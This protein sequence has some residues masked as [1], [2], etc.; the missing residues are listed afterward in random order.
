MGDD[1]TVLQALGLSANEQA[2]Y[3]LLLSRPPVTGQT[4]RELTADRVWAGATEVALRRLEELGL[5]ARLPHDPPRYVVI[6][7]D[8]GLEALIAARERS[9]VAARQR[10]NQ[11]AVRYRQTTIGGDPLDLVEV[12]HGREAVQARLKE[13]FRSVRTE[14]RAIDAPPYLGDPLDTSDEE[15]E[16]LRDGVRYRIIYDRQAVSLPGRLPEIEGSVVAGE[17]ARVTDVAL[18]LG[19]SDHPLAMLPLRTHPVDLETWLVIHDSVLLDALS[20]LFEM[21]WERAVPLHI[22]QERPDMTGHDAPNETD[23]A[24]LSLLA[25]GLTDKAVADHL[26]W[27]ERTAHRHLRLMMRRLDATTRF[28]AGYQAVRRGWLTHPRNGTDGTQ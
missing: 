17:E 8:A 21:Y 18:K 5:V 9:L 28:Q 3:E 27:H 11:L 7:A 25:A 2:L 26:G 22:K 13:L 20:A 19:L 24:L 1:Q 6:P 4:L 23:R 16:H 15:L 12:V 14:M 10:M